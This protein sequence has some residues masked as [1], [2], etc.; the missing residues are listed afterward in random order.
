MV[1]WF[2]I[3]SGG[4]HPSIG[5]TEPMALTSPSMAEALWQSL[6]CTLGK[7]KENPPASHLSPP[8][9]FHSHKDLLGHPC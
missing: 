3:T 9:L 1:T 7:V 8:P 4:A 2:V 5:S 6:D